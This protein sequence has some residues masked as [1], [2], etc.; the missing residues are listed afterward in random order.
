MQ[1]PVWGNEKPFLTVVAKFAH[2]TP[3]AFLS[4]VWWKVICIALI[5]PYQF[6]VGPLLHFSFTIYSIYRYFQDRSC[7]VNEYGSQRFLLFEW[8]SVSG[9]REWGKG[10]GTVGITE[11]ILIQALKQYFTHTQTPRNEL[12]FDSPR[13]LFTVNEIHIQL[14]L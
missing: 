6:L 1:F 14:R 10:G 9:V 13:V 3:F 7:L 4:A 8:F 12:E 5:N 2:P 11:N